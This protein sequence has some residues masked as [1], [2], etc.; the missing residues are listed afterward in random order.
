MR[1]S[2]LMIQV[3]VGTI[4]CS[5]PTEPAAVANVTLTPRTIVLASG[6][7]TALTA[8]TL[9]AKGGV[10]TNRV[11]TW[12]SSDESIATVNMSGV[13]TAGINRTGGPAEVSIT[14]SSE[15]KTGIAAVSVTPVP[16]GKVIIRPDSLVLEPGRVAQLTL[17]VQDA[18][19]ANLTGRS[20]TWRSLDTTV[21]KVNIS[22]QVTTVSY[23]GPEQRVTRIIATTENVSD[24]LTV[25][26]PAIPVHSVSVN[27]D[28]VTL[29]VHDT[30]DVIVKYYSQQNEE[31]TNR[32]ATISA[33]DTAVA[34]THQSHR[35]SGKNVGITNVIVTSGAAADTILVDVVKWLAL[36][37]GGEHTCAISSRKIAYCWGWNSNGQIGN[38]ETSD[39]NKPT[40]VNTQILFS[41]ITVGTNHTCGI[42]TDANAYC[43]GANTYGQLGDSSV[44]QKTSPTRVATPIQFRHISAGEAHTCGVS[45]D[46]VS[47]CWGNNTSGE[48]GINNQTSSTTAKRVLFPASR[49]ITSIEAR[50]QHTCAIAE[51]GQAY[52]WGLNSYASLGLGE[53]FHGNRNV[54]MLVATPTRFTTLMPRGHWHSCATTSGGHAECWGLNWVGALGN[55]GAGNQS[56]TPLPIQGGYAWKSLA[57]G[58]GHLVGG[59]NHTC[60]VTTTGNLYCWGDNS[61]GQGGDGFQSNLEPVQLNYDAIFLAVVTGAGHTCALSDSGQA[62]C[63]GRNE[64]G[65]LGIGNKDSQQTLQRVRFH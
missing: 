13:V 28:S 12:S 31:L 4:S 22:G 53:D 52:C 62:Y 3:F 63:V 55:P 14:A 57:G 45:A 2:F 35:V 16:V 1:K 64:R 47:Y 56:A 11:I 41:S 10:L 48:L 9:D 21:A 49:R 23:T 5:S 42:S 15:G 32:Q 43:W 20:I 46:S 18:T 36:A 40:R 60:G 17:Q 38:S 58:G 8:A 61:F 6:A 54:P 37:A 30:I 34:R 29:L 19:G 7:A 65:S 51:G 44:D 25:T 59:R 39:V 33:L 27:I 50:N 24:T 26:V